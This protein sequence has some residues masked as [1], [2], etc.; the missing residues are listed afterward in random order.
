MTPDGLDRTEFC[1]GNL[2][3]FSFSILGREVQIRARRHDHCA[4]LDRTQ[5]SRQVPV[6]DFVVRNIGL[7]PGGQ[8]G[9]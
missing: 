8:H 9:Q 6:V 1:F 2:S 7:V 4:A 3:A 5:G